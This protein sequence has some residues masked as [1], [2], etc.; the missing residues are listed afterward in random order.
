ME[1]IQRLIEAIRSRQ[2]KVEALENVI[3]D[4][5]GESEDL[6]ARIQAQ[7]KERDALQDEI[8]DLT[9]DLVAAAK[10]QQS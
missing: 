1:E 2:S 8:D 9:Q 7:E 4:L 10:S 3:C 6:D 5:E